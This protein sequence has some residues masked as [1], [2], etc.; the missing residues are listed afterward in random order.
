MQSSSHNALSV[1]QLVNQ[2]K[3]LAEMSFPD[4]WVEGEVS[5]VSNPA[6]GH[7]YFTLKGDQSILRCVLFKNKRY[8]A[9]C[10]PEEGKTLLIRGK[11]S[12]YTA[13]CELQLIASYLEEAGEGAL[14]REF[15][16]LKAKLLAAGFFDQ[17]LKK[18]IP[19][20]PRNI[21]VVTSSTA[22]ALQD[23]LSTIANRYPIT[24]VT[25]FPASV[26]GDKAAE[27]L[28]TM[29]NLAIET[30]PSVILLVRG[31]GS[32]E[33]LHAFNSEQLAEQIY[34]SPIPIISGVG[35]ETDFCIA[36]FV[37]D[38][39]ALTPTDAA[40]LA[41]PD[42]H[43]EA[44]RIDELQNR[45]S[46]EI[47]SNLANQQQNKDYLTTKLRE[48][49]LIIAAKR[50]AVD[51]FRQQMAFF[52]ESKISKRRVQASRLISLLER[53]APLNTVARL[54]ERNYALQAATER[55]WQTQFTHK[56]QKLDIALSKLTTLSPAA[57]LERGYAI[58]QTTDGKVVRDAKFINK[59]QLLNTRV[60]K[61]TVIS[62]AK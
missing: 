48:P 52:L 47:Q 3:S 2:F 60:Y 36:D 27:E 59:G 41:T 32:T 10:L 29:L 58:M 37:A 53:L 62:E 23:V 5:Q 50:T 43:E 38:K 42:R 13:R 8:Q 24:N 19:R 46:R 26:Q 1:A 61:G 15:E 17:Q 57:T 31:G 11:V 33:D 16:Q 18:P 6:S 30:R 54:F 56:Q 9:A 21:A 4:V 22:A 40:Q 28:T 12:V 34:A 49:K 45:L 55:N 20:Y 51:N 39:R 7:I 14:R 44:K 25:L 35:H